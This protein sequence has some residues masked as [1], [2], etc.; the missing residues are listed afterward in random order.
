[1]SAGRRHCSSDNDKGKDIKLQAEERLPIERHKLKIN[2]GRE[3]SKK[4][5]R[6]KGVRET[7]EEPRN[8]E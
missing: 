4:W 2:E 5:R 7:F 1:M 6:L 3:R 8:I